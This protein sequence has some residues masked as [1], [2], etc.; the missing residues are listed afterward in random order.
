MTDIR[1]GSM[2]GRNFGTVPTVETF[3]P[4]WAS[5][6]NLVAGAVDHTYVLITSINSFGT[7]NIDTTNA[8]PG[9][10]LTIMLEG[11]DGQVAFS[12][13]FYAIPAVS[14]AGNPTIIECVFS[15]TDDSGNNA[16]IMPNQFGDIDITKEYLQP[17]YGSTINIVTTKNFT[18]ARVGDLTGNPTITAD[19]T[20]TLGDELIVM[21]KAS[22]ATR[23]ANFDSKYIMGRGDISIPSGM[24]ANLHFV[25]DG[26]KWCEVARF[27][28]GRYSGDYQSVSFATPLTIATNT[29]NTIIEVATMTGNIA[30]VNATTTNA[31]QGDRL[32]MIF[33]GGASDYTV[34]F[35]TNFK[36]SSAALTVK[37][38]KAS[39]ANF[40][41]NGSVWIETGTYS[42][43]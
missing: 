22:A 6:I 21:L 5:T 33:T 34:T 25:F 27:I 29:E 37:A 17:P 4:S 19:A 28:Q 9:Q 7:I 18:V 35:S 41:Y 43:V 15:Q 30:A 20:N 12:D 3:T 32:S 42:I 11:S 14:P 39:T 31:K 38:S 1:Q 2:F 10:K 13:G 40:I 36:A 23:V 24:I 26:S 8:L 16:F